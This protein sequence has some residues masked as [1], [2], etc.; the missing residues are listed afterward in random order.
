M[1][2][3]LLGDEKSTSEYQL[4]KSV[5]KWVAL[6]L[7]LT[8]AVVIAISILSGVKFSDLTK[9]GYLTFALAAGV[10][11]SRLLVQILRFR[12]ITLGLA[13]DPKTQPQRVGAHQGRQRVR[14]SLDASD[15]HGRLHTHRLVEGK[16]DRRREGSLDRLL[17]GADRDLCRR[18]SRSHRR[19]LR[20]DERS[21][22]HRVDDNPGR[23]RS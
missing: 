10:C 17:R 12:V 13:G 21:G 19:G 1:V 20:P 3:I 16:G 22:G 23:R 7:L 4:P 6:G 9:L 11:A 15:E 18:R 14:L 8:S 5:M 2:L